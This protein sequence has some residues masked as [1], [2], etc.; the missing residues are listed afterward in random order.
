MSLTHSVHCLV[1]LCVY[2]KD[3]TVA[4]A[5]QCNKAFAELFLN[6]RPYASRSN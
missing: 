5:Q 2:G 1:R 3:P 4:L 6:S